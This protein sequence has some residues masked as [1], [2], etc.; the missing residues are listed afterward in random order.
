[1]ATT[2][3]AL[4]SPNGDKM[5]PITIPNGT[6]I[7]GVE[8]AEQYGFGIVDVRLHFRKNDGTPLPGTGNQTGWVAGLSGN[9]NFIGFIPIPSDEVFSGLWVQEEFGFGV[10][11]FRLKKRKRSDG[12]STPLSPF[13]SANMNQNASGEVE[14]PLNTIAEGITVRVQAGYGVVNMAVE[15]R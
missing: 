15:Y 11:N 9:A 7:S 13:V 14:I 5:G 2:G 1:M 10:V 12:A 6:E 8:G 4:G 3:F